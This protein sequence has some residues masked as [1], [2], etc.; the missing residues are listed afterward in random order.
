MDTVVAFGVSDQTCGNMLC[1]EQLGDSIPTLNKKCISNLLHPLS[2]G[3]IRW[4]LKKC[5]AYHSGYGTTTLNKICSG[6]VKLSIW[7]YGFRDILLTNVSLMP[8]LYAKIL[9]LMC[10]CTWVNEWAM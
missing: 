9:I 1:I 8:F 7:I 5:W 4:R 6:P 10:K 2:G 3:M